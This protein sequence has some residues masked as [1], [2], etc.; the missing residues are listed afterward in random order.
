MNPL[1]NSFWAGSLYL[2]AGLCGLVRHFLLEPNVPNYP[3]APRWL[4][5]VYFMF[6]AVLIFAGL[7]FLTVWLSGE[8]ATI[9]PGATGM[10]VLLALAT[11]TYKGSMLFNVARQRYPVE[12]W[13]RLNRISELA[14]CSRRK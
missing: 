13:A 8:A 12:T 4:L 3:Q 10:G 6:A 7:R 2:L 11:F 5:N 1:T 14:R 9:P